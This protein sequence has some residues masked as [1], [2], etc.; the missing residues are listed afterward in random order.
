MRKVL[1]GLLAQ[2]YLNLHRLFLRRRIVHFSQILGEPKEVLIRLPNAPGEILFATP[3]LKRIRKNYGESR[4][5]LLLPKDRRFILR[6][7]PWYEGVILEDE[8][9]LP[10]SPSFF[11]WKSHLRRQGFDLYIDL[12]E[13]DALLGRLLSL[14]SG[15]KVRMV[16]GEGSPFFNCEIHVR[17]DHRN[18]VEKHLSLVSA[19][20]PESKEREEGIP[21]F[22][23]EKRER[24][25]RDFFR[26][27]GVKNGERLIGVDTF[28]WNPLHLLPLLREFE[29]HLQGRILFLDSGR[30]FHPEDQHVGK[31]KNAF[32]EG[33][34]EGWVKDPILL[35]SHLKLDGPEIIQ[36]CCLFITQKTDYFSLAYASGCPTILFLKGSESRYFQPPAK[37]SLKT[38]LMDRR[39]GFPIANMIEWAKEQLHKR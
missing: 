24:S 39:G 23:S 6:E 2:I 35:P 12:C 22:L 21:L 38:I 8:R 11:R 26:F 18:E 27:Q 7:N 33:I 29:N 13:R 36:S 19:F 17:E 3:T 9:M 28:R 15:A 4:I 10:F 14:A 16:R 31:R 30:A 5:F 37:V 1:R 34:K 25:V 32:L 20:L